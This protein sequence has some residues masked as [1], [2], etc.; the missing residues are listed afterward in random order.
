MNR[1]FSF[2]EEVSLVVNDLRKSRLDLEKEM[3]TQVLLLWEI[4]VSCNWWYSCPG[5]VSWK[6]NDADVG[7]F[8]VPLLGIKKGMWTSLFGN[9]SVI[10]KLLGN[11]TFSKDW[12][13]EELFWKPFSSSC[14][15]VSKN[16][17]WKC[18]LISWWKKK[19]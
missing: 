18:Q 19:P 14:F 2:L 16:N 8:F 4:L 6:T 7:I 10:K 15:I 13:R 3:E 5:P 12:L 1:I 9:P 11:V 17:K